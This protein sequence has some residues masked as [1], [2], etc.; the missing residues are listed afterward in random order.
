MCSKHARNVC[1]NIKSLTD[2]QTNSSFP[3]SIHFEF[4]GHLTIFQ[5]I[6]FCILKI[7]SLIIPVTIDWHSET[8]I[9]ST[10]SELVVRNKRSFKNY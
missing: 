8:V 6:L 4:E 3:K 7:V 1:K 10:F 9:N 2:T 5:R